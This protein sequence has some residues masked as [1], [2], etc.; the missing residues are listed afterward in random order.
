MVQ[1]KVALA[2][3]WFQLLYWFQFQNGSIK[4]FIE[5]GF[6]YEESLFQFQN[7]SIKSVIGS[8]YNHNETLFQF[9]NGS[10]KRKKG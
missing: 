2:I 6:G 7:G 10:I 1:L 9:Q 3:I 8:F 5:S 4:R